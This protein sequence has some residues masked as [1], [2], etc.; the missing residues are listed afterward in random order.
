MGTKLLTI[1]EA[2][3]RSAL[4][5]GTIRKPIYQRRLPSVKLG[6]SV[7]LREEDLEALIRLGLHPLNGRRP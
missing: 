2:A 1:V 4:R 3:E 7:R 6:R 5:P